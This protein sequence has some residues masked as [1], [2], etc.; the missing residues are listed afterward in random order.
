MITTLDDFIREFRI[1]KDMGWI[2]TRRK[3]PTGIGK[4]LE[5]MLDIPENNLDEPD[6]GDYELK[7]VRTNAASMLTMFTKSPEPD[8]SNVLLC[9]KYGYTSS[10][11]YGNDR[12]VL[13]ST[14]SA[15]RFTSVRGAN[16]LK[17]HCSHDRIS[18]ESQEGIEPI[19]WKRETLKNCFNRKYRG[20]FVYAYADTR[21][22]GANEHFH[23]VSAFV[24]SGFG[25]DEFS[26]L[27]EAGKIKIDLRMGQ[28]ADGRMHDH[29]TGFRIHKRDEVLLFKNREQIV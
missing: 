25:Y 22:R 15:D 11:I 8:R 21:G 4:T 13:H 9:Q 2:L 3:G 5:D 26:D 14:L 16:H 19:Y 17:I 1:V 18:I 20:R 10:D 27:L 28:Y 23:F 6:F 24:V 29:G 12:K 7:S